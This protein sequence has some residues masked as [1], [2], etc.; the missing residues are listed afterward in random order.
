MIKTPTTFIIGAGASCGYGLPTGVRLLEMARELGARSNVYQLLL[1][2]SFTTDELETFISELRRVPVM[3]LD[4]FLEKRQH[5]P[6]TIKVGRGIIAGLMGQVVSE[7]R[8]VEQS[9]ADEWWPYVFERMHRGA[10]TG[11]AFVSGNQQLRFVTFNF[12][13]FIEEHLARD[14]HLMFG[15][16]HRDV[17]EML[18]T[19][20][21]IH[22]HGRLPNMPPVPLT[23][24]TVNGVPTKWCEWLLAAAAQINVVLDPISAEVVETARAAVRNAQVIC[25]LGLAYDRTNLERLGFPDVVQPDMYGSAFGLSDGEKQ[26]VNGWLRAQIHL[27]TQEQRCVDVLRQFRIF[28]D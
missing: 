22:V 21:V 15:F 10:A 11:D 4:S 1:A 2:C 3:S 9:S 7:P 16:S 13:T 23:H 25:F 18:K 19:I 6:E 12:D 17:L 24:D 20:P 5:R 26:S 28:R 14:V 8:N 27:G